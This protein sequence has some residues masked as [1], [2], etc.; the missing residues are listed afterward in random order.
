MLDP[1]IDGRP[2]IGRWIAECTPQSGFPAGHNIGQPVALAQLV[3]VWL[4]PGQAVI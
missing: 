3:Q 1:G 4:F 2:H